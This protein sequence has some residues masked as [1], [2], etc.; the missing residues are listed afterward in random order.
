MNNLY[1]NSK[2]EILP[3]TF[4]KSTGQI[5]QIQYPERCYYLTNSHEKR[6]R[7][8]RFEHLNFGFRYC[9]VFRI[10]RLGF[11][12]KGGDLNAAG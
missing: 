8:E 7:R 10:L 3:S 9:L 11:I 6:L 2:S 1:E 5:N 4:L 12:Q